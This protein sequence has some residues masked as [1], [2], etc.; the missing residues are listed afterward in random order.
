MG[1]PNLSKNV[2]L[3]KKLATAQKLMVRKFMC[4]K[5]RPVVVNGKKT[6]TEPWLDWQIRS[7][8]RAGSEIRQRNL[9]IDSLLD[10]E[11][12]SWAAHVA[13]FGQDGK[14]P[15]LSK[16]L[17]AWRNLS[18]WRI[19]QVYNDLSWSPIVHPYP[20]LPKRWEDSLPANWLTTLA[21]VQ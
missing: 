4:L 3:D 14:P 2:N 15:H 19:Q 13:R 7:M 11:R 12:L 10:A 16:Y 17:V 9:E 8:S 1:P 5:R 21:P 20:F 18:W 6:G